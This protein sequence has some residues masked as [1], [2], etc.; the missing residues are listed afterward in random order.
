M[1][2]ILVIAATVIPSLFT[3][4]NAKSAFEEQVEIQMGAPIVQKVSNHV[5][6]SQAELDGSYLSSVFWTGTKVYQN[7]DACLVLEQTFSHFATARN[8]R[9]HAVENRPVLEQASR[10]EHCEAQTVII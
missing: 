10:V 7:G 6:K 5:Y 4:A 2:N 3:C 9:V 1:K 8:T